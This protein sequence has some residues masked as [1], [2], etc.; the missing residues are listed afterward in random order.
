MKNGKRRMTGGRDR[1]TQ[2]VFPR[3]TAYVR[4]VATQTDGAAGPEILDSLLH[5]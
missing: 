1:L 3:E 5:Y 4:F 2:N